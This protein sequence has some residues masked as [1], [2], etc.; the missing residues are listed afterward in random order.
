MPVDI[1]SADVT[2][3]PGLVEVLKFLQSKEGFGSTNHPRFGKY[4]LLHA[5]VKIYWQILRMIYS[6]PMLAG[7]RHDLILVFA[8]WHPYHYSHIALW[9]QSRYTFLGPAYFLLFPTIS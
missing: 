9:H 3:I 1:Y 8:L 7:L 6:Y 4:S 2:A 5:D